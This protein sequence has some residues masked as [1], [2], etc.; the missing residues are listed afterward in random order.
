[1]LELDLSRS[2]FS[3]TKDGKRALFVCVEQN[4]FAIVIGEH[5]VRRGGLQ[6]MTDGLRQFMDMIDR[7]GS[8]S[9]P[10]LMGDSGLV[11]SAARC[12]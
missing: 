11:V 7:P 5:V 3:G 9:M 6:A 12:A 1:M 2:L 4:E 10:L 8:Q